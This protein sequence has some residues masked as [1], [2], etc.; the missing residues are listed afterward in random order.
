MERPFANDLVLIGF[1]TSC[2]GAEACL[3]AVDEAVAESMLTVDI[4][5][6]YDL[7]H[8]YFEARY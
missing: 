8:R 2:C 1:T 3:A 6:V 4:V 5:I 7:T